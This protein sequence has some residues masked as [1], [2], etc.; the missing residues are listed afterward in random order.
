M[1]GA[2]ELSDIVDGLRAAS[3]FALKTAAAQNGVGAALA[4]ALLAG[5][6]GRRLLSQGDLP[7]IRAAVAAFE[8]PLAALEAAG[9]RAP[10]LRGHVRVRVGVRQRVRLLRGASRRRRR[11]PRWSR[12]A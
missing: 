6:E 1:A 12:P 11:A 8:G 5:I 9:R 2:D 3:A 7:Q 10:A 4:Q